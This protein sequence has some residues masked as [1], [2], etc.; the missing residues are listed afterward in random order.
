MEQNIANA[1]LSKYGDAIAEKSDIRHDDSG[2]EGD[3]SDDN[4]NNCCDDDGHRHDANEPDVDAMSDEQYVEYVQSKNKG[5]NRAGGNT[6]IKGVLGDYAE[7]REQQK[8]AYKDKMA[9]NRAMLERMA[10]T[11]RD[12]PENKVED[13]LDSDEED[14]ERIRKARLEQWK[15]KQSKQDNSVPKNKVFGYLKQITS[16]EYVD[17]IDNEPPNVF[18]IIH[19][20]QSYVPACVLLNNYLGQMAVKYRSIKFLKILSTE[21]KSNYH[22]AALPSLLVYIGGKL[23]VSFIPITE[24]LGNTFDKEDIEL[25]LSSYDIIPNPNQAKRWETSL[26]TKSKNLSDDD[27]DD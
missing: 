14:L 16:H 18:V 9:A 27:Y 17:E 22:D 3:Y 12:Q 11:T 2:D 5:S 23:L 1:L 8:Q 13:E 24:E 7:F 10:F 26:A 15:S 20:F 19:L 4:I 6:G 21:A 25:L